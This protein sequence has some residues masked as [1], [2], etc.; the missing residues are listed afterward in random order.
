MYLITVKETILYNRS[1]LCPVIYTRTLLDFA[2]ANGV[3]LFSRVP[4]LTF[5]LHGC[6]IN[7]HFAKNSVSGRWVVI[8]TRTVCPPTSVE[9]AFV[10]ILK[11]VRT[12]DIL[13]LGAFVRPQCG[14]G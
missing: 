11:S 2:L 13:V 10:G 6:E 4:A 9:G 5:D 8:F 1:S 12:L 3:L 7:S 14:K